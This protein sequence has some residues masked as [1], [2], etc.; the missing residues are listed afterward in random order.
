MYLIKC[1]LNLKKRL[2]IDSPEKLQVAINKV[3]NVRSSDPVLQILKDKNY[4]PIILKQYTDEIT[5][6]I[7]DIPDKDREKFIQY[8]SNPSQQITFPQM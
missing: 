1:H 4:N 7:E 6:L 2:K 3:L 8:I 5:G